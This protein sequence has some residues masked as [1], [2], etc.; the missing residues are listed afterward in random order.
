MMTA[1]DPERRISIW[2]V[3]ERWRRLFFAIFSLQTAGIIGL[4]VWHEVFAVT[5]DS[6]AETVF[7]ISSRA[8]PAI[9]VITAESVVLTEVYYVVIFGGIVE[10]YQ[11]RIKQAADEAAAKAD[12][13][14]AARGEAIGE[15]RGVARGEARGEARGAARGAAQEYEKWA[16]WNRRRLEAEANG[17]PF[18]E[19]PPPP[20][21]EETG[22][23][24]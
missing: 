15:A 13:E 20:P 6:W 8:G 7:A 12:A 10:R 17:L 23:G 3:P 18:D 24:S 11:N 2:S 5:G 22:N 9:G 14:G 4:A 19:P 16:E 21:G 1:P